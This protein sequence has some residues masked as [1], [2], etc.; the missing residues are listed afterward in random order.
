MK[1][2]IISGASG[3]FGKNLIKSFK[4]K[5]VR[6]LCLSTKRKPTIRNKNVKWVKLD[7]YYSRLSKIKFN[8]SLF[9]LASGI[10]TVQ[11]SYKKSELLK[12][13]K[14]FKNILSF[15]KKNKK[16]ILIFFSSYSVYG[17]SKKKNKENY[18][19]MPFSNYARR[20]LSF[21][22]QL[23]LVSSNKLKVRII[24]FS[25]IYGPHLKKQ[26]VWDILKKINNK[27]IKLFGSGNEE[28]DFLYIDDAVR[29][30]NIISKSKIKNFDIFNCGTGNTTKIK[31]LISI[32]ARLLKLKK[33]I[34]FSCNHHKGSP[35]VIKINVQKLKKTGWKNK[36]SLK[37]GLINYLKWHKK[38]I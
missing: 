18:Q 34:N 33:K 16:T 31:N 7:R 5:N 28:R 38:K 37:T 14:I 9:I 32:V 13:K 6:L 30:V 24:R 12:E 8:F 19:C 29:A 35:S 11:D 1:N 2:I 3:F 25:S 36:V 17:D 22:K 27:N 15:V 4:N 10:G 20:K 23:K 21:E 26:L